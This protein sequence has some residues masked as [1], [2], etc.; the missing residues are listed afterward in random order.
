MAKLKSFHEVTRSL[1]EVLDHSYNVNQVHKFTR[2][3]QTGLI[4]SD[5]IAHEKQEIEALKKKVDTL[6]NVELIKAHKQKIKNLKITQA[7]KQYDQLL[8]EVTNLVNQLGAHYTTA[9]IGLD[10]ELSIYFTE[11]HK[12]ITSRQSTE[13]QLYAVL[14]KLERNS[15]N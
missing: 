10:P 13:A 14:G 7:N 2:G 6:Q 1:K 8:T 9:G 15:T 4:F 12:L 11:L 3:S 5:Y